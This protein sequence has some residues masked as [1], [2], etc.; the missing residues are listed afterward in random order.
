MELKDYL[1]ILARRWQIILL[2]TLTATIVFI[3]GSNYIPPNYQAV[4]TLQ[5]ITPLAGSS[6]STYHETAFANRLINTY[7]QVATSDQVMNELKEKLG[8]DKLPDISVKIIPDSEIIKITV[9]GSNPSLVAQ[10]ANGL[11]ALIIAKQTNAV[12][13]SSNSEEL[14]FLT[15]RRDA[16]VKDLEEANQDLDKM[17][18]SSS[19]TA[20][21]LAVLDRA[22]QLKQSSYQS[23]LGQYQQALIA[24]TVYSTATSRSTLA[25]LGEQLALVEKDLESLDQE[26]KDLSTKSNEYSQQIL[27]LRQTIQNYQNTY[28]DILSRYDSTLGASLRQ[29]RAQ[30]ILL[31]SPASEPTRSTA[32]SRMF[33][34]GL[35][36]LLGCIGGVI[37]AFLYDSLDTRIYSAGQLAQVTSLPMLGNF[38]KIRDRKDLTVTLL[39]QSVAVHKEYW[40]LCTRLMAMI[41]D[42]SIKTILVTSPS[43]MD[44]KS[45][46]IPALASGFA[47]QNCKVLVVDADLRRPQQ[48]K[49][50]QLSGEQGLDTFLQDESCELAEMIQ[51][52]V[53]PG[54]DVLPCITAYSDPT[55]LLQQSRLNALLGNI[56]SYDV[57]LFDA[58]ALLAVPDAYDLAKI[59]DGV[60]IIVQLGKTT[61]DNLRAV[62]DHLEAVGSK[63]LGVI[64]NQVPMKASPDYYGRKAWWKKRFAGLLEKFSVKPFTHTGGNI[65]K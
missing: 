45:T 33:V 25:V 49:L 23:L 22:I 36:L 18:E 40:M 61:S 14:S 15:A 24:D 43:P 48:Q 1:S 35:G 32:L 46:V 28:A 56:S 53:K 20:A 50:Y 34:I 10:T 39:N 55:D 38:P 58:P 62:C 65:H 2:M 7:A 21:Q 30:D 47:R 9:E 26:Y 60:I 29:Q 31:V 16:L 13:D 12:A 44:G 51:K 5:V 8:R 41:Q 54:I 63:L 37:L 6:G 3:F 52:N 59:V 64:M 17:I 57:V 19:Q 11:A 4:A 42:A 27:L